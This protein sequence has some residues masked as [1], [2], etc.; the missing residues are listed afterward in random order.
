M[1]RTEAS[2]WTEREKVALVEM[3]LTQQLSLQAACDKYGLLRED[4]Q[5][6]VRIY[7]RSIRAS[8]G[9]RPPQSLLSGTLE[10]PAVR[11]H[12]T[13]PVMRGPLASRSTTSPPQSPRSVD[14][15]EN[16][17]TFQPLV[18]PSVRLLAPPPR[19]T[20][21]WWW[22]AG[23]LC[24]AALGAASAV[25]FVVATNPTLSVLP[26]AAANDSSCPATMVELGA[27]SFV[28]GTDSPS[29]T[30]SLARPAHRV[31][32]DSYCLATHETTV[33]QYAQCV[34][35]GACTPAHRQLDFSALP[36]DTSL[37][38][39]ETAHSTQCNG[40][41]ARRADHPINCVTHAQ[42]QQ[43]CR[44][45]GGRLPTEAEWELAA[46][47]S[48]GRR[49]PWGDAPPSS[50]HFNACGNECAR[51]HRS[52]ELEQELQ[53]L[54]FKEDDGFTGTSPV[55]QFPRGASPQGVSDLLGNVFE[56]TAEGLYNYP[57]NDWSNPHGPSPADSYVIRGGSFGSGQPEFSDAAVRFAV[58]A[59]HFSHGIGFRCA[60][61]LGGENLAM[62]R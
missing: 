31:S 18:S 19:R 62:A 32:V 50:S 54:M 12:T 58:S 52:L 37:T 4:V 33:A 61:D 60:A 7:Q 26:A 15:S 38:R 17:S 1:Q 22:A 28:M 11:P 57:P 5:A 29:A 24:S 51:W 40:G 59:D 45:I 13:K 2:H 34:Q 25:G 46:R 8:L 23:A 30:L 43:Y 21:G 39:S 6:W 9:T 27:T 56:W 10:A 41:D 42:A 20:S 47:G 16:P 35:G 49:F 3:L 53:G 36:Q 48:E 44:W 14:L 55:G